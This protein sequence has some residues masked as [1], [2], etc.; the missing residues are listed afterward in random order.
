M[1][2]MG[3]CAMIGQTMINIG[4]GARHRLSE[5]SAAFFLFLIVMLAYP[6]IDNI[7][8]SGLCGVMFTVVVKTMDWP[9]WKLMAIAAMPDAWRVQYLPPGMAKAKIRRADA[10]TVFIVTSVTCFTDLAVGVGCGTVFACLMFAKESSKLINVDGE[11]QVKVDLLRQAAG[12]V[13]FYQVRGI[14]FFGSVS[15]FLDLFDVERDPE[16]VELVFDAGFISDHSAVEA[17]KKLGE[18]YSDA[19]KSLTLR[20]LH[21]RC[22]SLLQNAETLLEQKVLIRDAV[23]LPKLCIAT[24]N[25][26]APSTDKVHPCPPDEDMTMEP[27]SPLLSPKV[28]SPQLPSAVIGES[29]A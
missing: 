13:K 9:S 23:S 2:G 22:Q 24:S 26:S 21:V 6:L 15:R 5:G 27:V 29:E 7:P 14:L 12:D 20:Q 1:G 10:L 19:G 8:I 4:S 28:N 16:N 17:L 25:P 18:R 11:E 3:G